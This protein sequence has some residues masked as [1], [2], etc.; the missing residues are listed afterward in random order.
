MIKIKG[1]HYLFTILNTGTSNL[2]GTYWSSIQNIYPK[3]QLFWFDSCGY[4]GFKAFIDQDDGDINK[5]FYDTKK[6]NKK[7]NIVTLVIVTF[8]KDEKLSQNKIIKPSSMAADLFQLIS[9]F[10]ELNR[11][12]DEVILN[13]V[14]EQ[15]QNKTSDTCGAFQLYFYKNL[16]D[17]L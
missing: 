1:G 8:S 6:F 7:E 14:D 3:K 10:A 4:L 11:V 16:F 9:D 12:K 13:F 2:P 5:N 15:V 17:P